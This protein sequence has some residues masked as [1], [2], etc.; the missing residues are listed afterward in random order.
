MEAGW[1]A[2]RTALLARSIT[3]G[4]CDALDNSVEAQ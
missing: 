2:G 3:N 1:S 4:Q